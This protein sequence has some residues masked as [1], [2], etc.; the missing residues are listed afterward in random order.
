MNH[1]EI[2]FT[3]IHNY[4]L[5]IENVKTYDNFAELQDVYEKMMLNIS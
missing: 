4:M 1:N 2:E 5:T 3:K